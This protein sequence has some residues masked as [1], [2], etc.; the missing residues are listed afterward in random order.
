MAISVGLSTQ[1]N[2]STSVANPTVLVPSDA[3]TGDTLV[4]LLITN[5][6]GAITPPTGWTEMANGLM[7]TG[8]GGAF[9]F[10]RRLMG[11]GV[12]QAQWSLALEP[13]GFTVPAAKFDAAMTTIKGAST[14]TVGT[15]FTRPASSTTTDVPGVTVPTGGLLV[16]VGGDKVSSQTLVTPPTGMTAQVNHIGGGGGGVSVLIAT[17]AT[18]GASG[19]KTITYALASSTAYGQALALTPS[20]TTPPVV[21]AGA[22]ATIA[23]GATKTLA[24]TSTGTTNAWTATSFPYSTAPTITNATSATN[25]TVTPTKPGVYIFRLT[26]TNTDGTATDDMTLT[27]TGTTV[28]PVSTLNAGAFVNVGAAATTEEALGDALDTTYA[29]GPTTAGSSGTVLLAPLQAGAAY[30]ARIRLRTSVAPVATITFDILQGNTVIM[31]RSQATTTTFTTY[32]F[33]F[34]AGEVSALTNG[35]DLRARWTVQ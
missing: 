9:S 25:A 24:G 10:I 17:Q 7:L 3:T 31:T 12:T 6:Q 23:L 32:S 1:A 30:T 20:A 33:T 29:E 4:A 19:T 22:D 21:N 35:G 11:S 28:T 13:P 27:V 5:G 2:G 34:S 26:G 18:S 14:V 8:A 15:A 16:V